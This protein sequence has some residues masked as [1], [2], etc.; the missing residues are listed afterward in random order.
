MSTV[1]PECRNDIDIPGGGFDHLGDDR[2]CPHCKAML[3]L[4]YE[5]FYDDDLSYFYYEIADQRK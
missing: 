4:V 2:E 1:C 3:V 5:E